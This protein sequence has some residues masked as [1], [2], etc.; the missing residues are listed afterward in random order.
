VS[1]NGKERAELHEWKHVTVV[2]VPWLRRLVAGLSPR[3]P[4]FNPGS[5]HMGFV[6]DKVALGQVF[7]PRTSVFSCQ[8]HFTGAPLQGKM[9]KLIIFITGLHNKHQ[10]CGASVS[11]AA[12]PFTTKN[13]CKDREKEKRLRCPCSCM[14]T[15]RRSTLT[16]PLVRNLCAR[17]RRVINITFRSPYPPGKK[18][19]THRVEG[20]V[21]P[22][23]GLDDL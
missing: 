6:V 22:R 1:E 20:W 9:K 10:G 23:A 19:G 16:S 2:A 17:L 14:K 4:G 21:G 18:P 15:Y 8:F 3:R 13:K 5:V 12:G 11:S 7:L